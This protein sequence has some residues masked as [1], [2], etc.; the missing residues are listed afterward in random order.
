MG[1]FG[2]KF[3][4]CRKAAGLK[5]QVAAQLIGVSQS[6][7]SEYERDIYEPTAEVL[8]KMSIAYGVSVDFLLGITD[9]PND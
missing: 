3:R 4:E 1:G 8:V 5:Q 6:S 7:I 2:K 9:D